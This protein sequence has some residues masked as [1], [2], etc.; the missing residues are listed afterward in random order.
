MWTTRNAVEGCRRPAALPEQAARLC[1]LLESLITSEPSGREDGHT[2]TAASVVAT[3]WRDSNRWHW[4][5]PS[6]RD[7]SQVRQFCQIHT[8]FSGTWNSLSSNPEPP[9]PV[10]YAG[11]LFGGGVNKFSWGQR[12]RG[13]G[14]GSPLVR[15]SGGSCNLVQEIS[16]NI[17]KFS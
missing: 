13:S 12:E 4:S 10:A 7:V 9:P 3:R 11:I 1:T 17:V 8:G 14:G 2:P 16:F 15:G 5:T 6:L